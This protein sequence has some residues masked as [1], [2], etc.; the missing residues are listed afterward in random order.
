MMAHVTL[1]ARTEFFGDRSSAFLRLG[2]R[3]IKIAD[4]ND[5][6]VAFIWALCNGGPAEQIVADTG[7]TDEMRQRM[8]TVLHELDRR[9][10]LQRPA[11]AAGLPE[12]DVERFGRFLH[13]LS[14]FEHG[15]INRFDLLK[16]LRNTTIMVIG[17]GGLGSWIL[18]QLA[19]FGIGGLVLVDGDN[20]E[21]HN[22][23][24]AIL[25][26][27]DTI[28]LPKVEAARTQLMRFAPSTS[29]TVHNTYIDGPD[30]LK[31]LLDGVDFVVPTADEPRDEIRFWI[32]EACH[33]ANVPS[34]NVSGMK[35]GPL[36]QPGKSACYAC[37]RQ[38]AL[39]R[40]PKFAEMLAF[41]K[42]L[43]KGQSGGL[44]SIAAVTAGVAGMEILSFLV[45]DTPTT[46]NAVWEMN[47]NFVSRFAPVDKAVD[48]PVC[49]EVTR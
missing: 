44:S 20:V 19:C 40:N 25:F 38:I 1:R 14:E 43:P 11:S 10:F 9:G 8:K 22:L 5:E 39:S 2:Q 37:D 7:S 3:T 23:N 49:G 26:D 27:E 48:C 29:I 6:M 17:V 13:Y 35:V 41:R 4:C 12:K 34:L 21:V 32:A 36:T 31:T 46:R 30:A 24:R 47:G 45:S 28:G 42:S 16:R 18:Y 15:N 33:R